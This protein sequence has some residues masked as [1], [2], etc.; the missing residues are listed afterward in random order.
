MGALT[1]PLHLNH[2]LFVLLRAELAGGL[3]LGMFLNNMHDFLD[4]VSK[5]VLEKNFP[6]HQENR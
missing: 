3:Q 2:P 1:L 4:E 5:R 6:P